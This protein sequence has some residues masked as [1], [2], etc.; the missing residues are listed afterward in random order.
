MC[1]GATHDQTND[2]PTILNTDIGWDDDDFEVPV[3]AEPSEPSAQDTRSEDIAWMMLDETATSGADAKDQQ[4][5]RLCADK[6]T[7]DQAR[8]VLNTPVSRKKPRCAECTRPLNASEDRLC[9]RCA[10]S[11]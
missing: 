11:M 7:S 3:L 4:E 10:P 5:I 9:S 6:H 1:S 8:V 2:A